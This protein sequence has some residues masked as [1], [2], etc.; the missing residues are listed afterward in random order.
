M[1][2]VEEFIATYGVTILYSILTAV[3]SFIGLKLK[4]LYEKYINDKTKKDVVNTVCGAI[5]QLYS[6]LNGPEKL[7]KAIENITAVLNEKGITISDVEMRMLIESTVY[8]FKTSLVPE[9]TGV[10][11]IEE[12]SEKNESEEK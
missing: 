9:G 2:I 3:A 4:E 12:T 1:E 8:S 6:N 11:Q 10:K 5:N 7:D